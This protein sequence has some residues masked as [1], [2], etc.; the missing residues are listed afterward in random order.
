MKEFVNR[1]G[2]IGKLAHFGFVKMRVKTGA[3]VKMIEIPIQLLL[4]SAFSVTAAA[5]LSGLFSNLVRVQDSY[6][7]QPI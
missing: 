2:G 7:G 3:R 6:V 5:H 4:T 1:L